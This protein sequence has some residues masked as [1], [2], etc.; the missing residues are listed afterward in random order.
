MEAL[1]HTLKNGGALVIRDA[2]VADA[3]AILDYVD[4]TCGQSDFFSF[5]PGEFELSVSDEEEFIRGSL[6]ADNQLFIV[7]S[8][9]DTIVS[10]LHLTAN[11]RPRTRHCGE[12]GISVH[13]EYWGLGIGSM[14][15]DALI[16]W[17]TNTQIVTKINLRVRTDN[18]RAISLYE[19]KGFVNEGTIRRE[20]FIDGQYFDHHW[21]GLEL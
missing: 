20:I 2:A 19:R 11:S 3:G 7:G 21:M 15:L 16:D 18:D 12:F 10:T 17:A 4:V 14:M 5:G 6:E 8:I 1:K 9:D 13:Q